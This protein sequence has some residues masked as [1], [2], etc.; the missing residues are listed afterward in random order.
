MPSKK[1]S[2][3][4]TRSS[5]AKRV[6]QSANIKSN[7]KSPYVRA[8]AFFGVVVI[9]ISGFL[10]YSALTPKAETAPTVSQLI[11]NLYNAASP[12]SN[13][14]KQPTQQTGVSINRL[15]ENGPNLVSN[16]DKTFTWIVQLPEDSYEAVKSKV[17]QYFSDRSYKKH[18]NGQSGAGVSINYDG[19]KFS[20]RVD[21]WGASFNGVSQVQEKT[22]LIACASVD[23]FE[24]SSQKTE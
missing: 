24:V 3:K 4:S 12:A 15:Q 8:G 14:L 9:L 10:I 6:S 11:G 21:D 5:A 19:D 13:D 22:L 23:D 7:K 18:E 17:N 20:C 2:T 16:K 1:T